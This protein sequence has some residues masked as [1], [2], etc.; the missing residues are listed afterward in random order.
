VTTIPL[1]PNVTSVHQPLDAGITA[2]LKRRYK[3]RLLALVVWAFECTRAAKLAASCGRPCSSGGGPS[4]AAV[5]AICAS[6]QN[7]EPGMEVIGAQRPAEGAPVGRAGG[8]GP[9]G[10]TGHGE[11]T[12]A[13]ASSVVAGGFR[14]HCVAGGGANTSSILGGPGPGQ[15]LYVG[16]AANAFRRESGARPSDGID[17]ANGDAPSLPPR[18]GRL[19]GRSPA[20]DPTGQAVGSVGLDGAGAVATA[21]SGPMSGPEAYEQPAA[22]NLPVEPP[23]RLQNVWGEPPPAE[24]PPGAG[25][26]RRARQRRTT[27]PLPVRG[28]RDGAEAHLQDAAEIIK[29][30]WEASEPATTAH[31]WVKARLLPVEMEARLTA[32][33]G[34]YRNSLRAV[35]GEAAE[36]LTR[37]QSCVLSDRCFGD[38]PPVERQVAVET[39][40][41]L[42]SD[43]EAILDTADAEFEGQSS[44]DDPMDT[45]SDSDSDD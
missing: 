42:E 1:P 12:S 10:E 28:V 30:E 40:L 20:T 34:D 43:P 35:S 36:M 9:A 18:A 5:S 29:E 19:A 15:S 38:A 33:R 11:A 22:R 23:P 6:L 25:S 16:G 2:A 21:S 7:R 44:W 4:A 13:S 27:A 24:D 8:P 39:W 3:R 32:Q 26:R 37:M 41:E 31:C 45:G 17:W 14:P